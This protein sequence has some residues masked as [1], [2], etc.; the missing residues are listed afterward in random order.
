MRTRAKWIFVVK[1]TALG[2]RVPQAELF[3]L[4]RIYKRQDENKVEIRWMQL[5]PYETVSC[6]ESG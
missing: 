5:L 1:A 2:A 6:R 4:V 3:I